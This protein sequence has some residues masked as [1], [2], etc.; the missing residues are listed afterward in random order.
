MNTA[1]IVAITKPLL[2]K[3]HSSFP[4]YEPDVTMSPEE[5]VA[6]CARVSNP[7]NQMNS[8]TAPKLLQYLIRNSHWSPF[9]MVH[10]VMEIS[11]TRDIGRQILRHRSF[12][13]QEF[14]QRYADPTKD[15][16]F[17]IREARLQ[18]HKN[19]QNS[20]E[21]DDEVLQSDWAAFQ[22]MVKKYSLYAYEFAISKGIAKEQA[23]AVLPEGMINS[24]MYMSG[25]LRSFIHWIQ[26]RSDPS[27]Q[28]EHR[29]IA[30]SAKDAILVHF[31]S[32]KE[33]L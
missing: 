2:F 5:F 31:P 1:K 23:R 14:S 28:K 17:T 13:F 21:V 8:E 7:S 15:L 4:Q 10:L 26:V 33:N 3:S 9:E 12:S 30:E 16:G 11:T 32:I 24:T 18:D 27:T 19:R 6:Y 20:I 29:D 22:E 25:S